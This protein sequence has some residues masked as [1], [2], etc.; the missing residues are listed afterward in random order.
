[1][2]FHARLVCD[3]GKATTASDA[4]ATH[5]QT[6]Y[7]AC[8]CRGICPCA[9]CFTC[10]CSRPC[11]RGLLRSMLACV[12]VQVRPSMYSFV[13]PQCLHALVLDFA[14][15]SV[16]SFARPRGHPAIRT[17]SFR[18]CVL[19]SVRPPTFPPASH[20]CLSLLPCPTLSSA[21]GC[22]ALFPFINMRA[23]V[24]GCAGGGW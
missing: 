15:L 22:L 12:P 4:C 23:S 16:L 10:A 14:R 8:I 9:Y 19:L 5:A 6:H 2:F 3:T 18:P 13:C 7:I 1:M 24:R 17:F 21:P 11:I 20:L